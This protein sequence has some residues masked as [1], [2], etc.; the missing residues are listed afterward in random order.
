MRG[1]LHGGR[2]RGV[3]IGLA[4]LAMIATCGSALAL[5]PSGPPPL[6][7]DHGRMLEREADDMALLLGLRADQRPA[8]AAFL[9]GTRPPGPP[10]PDADPGDQGFLAQLAR[11]EADTARRSATGRAFY[12]ALDAR[13]RTAFD[14]LMRL[15]RPPGT[16]GP[17]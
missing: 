14:A 7:V 8:L 9:A 17:G 13:Q 5:D 2:A 12:T 6:K 3:R 1:S 10:Q 16:R 11:I 4:G 15:R